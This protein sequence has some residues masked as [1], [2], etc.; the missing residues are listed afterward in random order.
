MIKE[1][2]NFVGGPWENEIN[3]RDFI[4]RN[5]TPYYGNGDFLAGP[6]QNTTDLWNKIRDLKKEEIDRGGEIGRAHV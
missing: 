5:V 2:E 1:W 3:V 6:T 4:H